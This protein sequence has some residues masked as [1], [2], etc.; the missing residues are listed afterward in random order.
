MGSREQ[1]IPAGWRPELAN[2]YGR[3][4]A[5]RPPLRMQAFNPA[6]VEPSA[7][8]GWVSG[9]L[10][11]SQNCSA[12]VGG[13][14]V[15]CEGVGSMASSL[16]FARVVGAD[17]APLVWPINGTTVVFGPAS[18]DDNLGTEVSYTRECG[19]CVMCLRRRAQ[20]PHVTFSMATGLYYMFYT[21]VGEDSNPTR[22]VY[23]N[24][25]TTAVRLG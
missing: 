12:V 20:D 21:A 7:G 5:G 11:R 3:R 24:L 2:I 4:A 18:G 22:N 25:A 1:R 8:T 10:V 16:S 9:L 17:D 19:G 15:H 6:W 14:C 13:A 23:L